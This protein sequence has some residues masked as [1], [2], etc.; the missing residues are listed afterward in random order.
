MRTGTPLLQGQRQRVM[1]FLN[2][3]S[4]PDSLDHSRIGTK[5]FR[6]FC[7]KCWQYEFHSLNSLNTGD[8]Y[9]SEYRLKNIVHSALTVNLTRQWFHDS[10]TVSQRIISLYRCQPRR[11]GRERLRRA[12]KAENTVGEIGGDQYRTG[13]KI[14]SG[15]GPGGENQAEKK[16]NVLISNCWRILRRWLLTLI[17]EALP[18]SANSAFVWFR[19]KDSFTG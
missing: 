18:R 7:P 4:G 17:G 5:P 14:C 6:H 19:R 8:L 16:S 1:A 13:R 11:R 9:G 2:S 12:Q 10:P 3:Y 15:K